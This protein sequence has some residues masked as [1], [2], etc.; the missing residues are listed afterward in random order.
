M[1][2]LKAEASHLFITWLCCASHSSTSVVEEWTNCL[3]LVRDLLVTVEF[4]FFFCHLSRIKPV[5]VQCPFVLFPQQ[6]LQ[7]RNEP[8]PP[9]WYLYAG[10][11]FQRITN[12][13]KKKEKRRSKSCLLED[14]YSLSS[15]TQAKE[16][17]CRYLN[18]FL[19]MNLSLTNS[20]EK[21]DRKPKNM[22]SS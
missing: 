16:N 21:T 5:L 18:Y 15:T 22:Q 8:Q 13:K 12:L 1:R 17:D 19:Q 10:S 6:R 7:R 9:V 20:P 2:F 14:N 11:L 3:L 4:S